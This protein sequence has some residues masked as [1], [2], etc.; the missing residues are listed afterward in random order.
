MSLWPNGTD[1][2]LL[3]SPK[4]EYKKEIPPDFKRIVCCTLRFHLE[5]SK[6]KHVISASTAEGIKKKSEVAGLISGTSLGVAKAAGS[7][8]TRIQG[9]LGRTERAKHA[10]RA[11]NSYGNIQK[12]NKNK[13][14]KTNMLKLSVK[15]YFK[16]YFKGKNRKNP[17]NQAEKSK[18]AG[19]ISGTPV[20]VAKTALKKPICIEKKI[21]SFKKITPEN[22][23][24]KAIWV[25]QK[26]PILTQEPATPMKLYK[27][28][29]KGTAE[30]PATPI[31]L[32]RECA[33]GFHLEKTKRKHVITG[34]AEGIKQNFEVAGNISRTSLGVAKRHQ[35]NLKLSDKIYIIKELEFSSQSDLA[36]K[37]GV[38]Q[39]SNCIIYFQGIMLFD[40][41]QVESFH[42]KAVTEHTKSGENLSQDSIACQIPD[43]L[44]KF[45]APRKSIDN[46][47]FHGQL[48][49][50]IEPV[51]KSHSDSESETEINQ[52]MNNVT[53]RSQVFDPV[54]LQSQSGS[55]AMRGH[56]QNR[57]QP[58]M[59][60]IFPFMIQI[61]LN[62]HLNNQSN[63]PSIGNT[64]F[65]AITKDMNDPKKALQGGN[66]R[67][68]GSSPQPPQRNRQYTD[69]ERSHF[70]QGRGAIAGGQPR[71][72]PNR[73]QRDVR[74]FVALYDYDPLTMSPNP[75]AANE[76]LPFREGDI[77]K[78]FGDKDPDGFYRG[79][80][81][82]RIGFVPCNMVSEV[83][84]DA[85]TGAPIRGQNDNDPWAHL[86]VKKM[87]ALYDYDPQ[88]L[89]PNPDAE[90]ELAF[91]AG[92]HIYVFGDLDE[93][94]FYM[95]ELNGNRGLVPS[96]FLTDA[97]DG[98]TRHVSLR[99]GGGAEHINIIH[100][101]L[102]FTSNTIISKF[103]NV[104]YFNIWICIVISVNTMW[105]LDALKSA[106]KNWSFH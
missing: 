61:N 3:K 71:V 15:P 1:Q 79:E 84:Y 19:L 85:E 53:R 58:R 41:S 65:S 13:G 10:T 6:G 105:S 52:L 44:I 18:V 91:H 96:N 81:N 7:R 98:T 59:V 17:R 88:E 5:K 14:K 78:I 64:T 22:P 75:D 72:V 36:I 83:Q 101:Q 56:I 70:G 54:Q 46:N 47:Y 68:G 23:K 99:Q 31:E 21:V 28:R 93:D 69:H 38:T 103:A 89:S 50:R 39:Q 100:T 60:W 57:G 102:Q 66:N 35:K 29:N 25:E 106:R 86:H 67:I 16:G 90:M 73:Q 33:V 12:S 55:P 43:E 48:R 92:D 30:T 27:K 40:I 42:K 97:I 24:Y 9:G 45:N 51:Q 20:G 82:D 95:G 32:Y 62:K 2:H 11:S 94:G 26:M 34:S 104:Q 77:I 8:K 87:I 37:Y 80:L 49:M 4:C 76:E 63:I 74:Y